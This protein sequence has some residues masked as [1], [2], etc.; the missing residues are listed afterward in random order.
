MQYNTEFN[1][2]FSSLRLP[3][4]TEYYLELLQY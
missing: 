2:E 1:V 4:E 3:K